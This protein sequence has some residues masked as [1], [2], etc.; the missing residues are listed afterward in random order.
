MRLTKEDCTDT[1]HVK[2]VFFECTHEDLLEPLI[3]YY[4]D[5]D[6]YTY[7]SL[8]KE[9]LRNKLKTFKKIMKHGG[10]SSILHALKRLCNDTEPIT[11][12]IDWY[13]DDEIVI[14]DEEDPDNDIYKYNR[15]LD[16]YVK[17][18]SKTFVKPDNSAA[19]VLIFFSYIMII[20]RS[21]RGVVIHSE[22][23]HDSENQT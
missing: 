20:C 16:M 5:A 21:M 10:D 14:L 23:S 13:D 22:I 17:V 2:A 9:Q 18:S 3:Q 8:R 4:K 12:E 11:L 7:L 15:D 19:Y 1:C 6:E